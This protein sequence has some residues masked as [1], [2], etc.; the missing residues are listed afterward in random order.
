MN[1]I[2]IDL[3]LEKGICLNRHILLDTF[4]KLTKPQGTYDWL[5]LRSEALELIEKIEKGELY[6]K[7]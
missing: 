2:K 7:N 4:K 5:C 3:T 1:S 6:E